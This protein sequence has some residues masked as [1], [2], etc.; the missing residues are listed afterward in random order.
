MTATGAGTTEETPEPGAEA[1]PAARQIITAGALLALILSSMDVSI[2]GT[3]LPR[4]AADLGALSLYSWVG[5]SYGMAAAVVIPIGGKLGDLFGR[6]PLLMAGL[7]GFVLASL[8]GALA[9]NMALLIVARTVQ[10]V[11][12]GLLTANIFTLIGEI[13]TAERRAQIQGVFFSVAGLGMVAGPPL[14]GVIT[15]NWGWRWVFWI[16]VPLGALALGAVTAV[17]FKQLG[18]RWQDIDFLGVLT[19]TAGLVPLLFGLSLTGDGHAWGSPEVLG[20]V[21]GGLLVLGLFCLVES[22]YARQPLVPFELFKVN[23][24]AVLVVVS[25]LSAVAMMGTTFYV[26]LL[27]QGVLGVSAT[28]SGSLLIP[29]AVAMMVVPP[30]T[31]K[32]LPSVPH[33]RYLG[34][35]AF[36]LL[37]VGLV[38]LSRVRPDS[39]DWMPL[40]AMVIIGIGVGIIFPLTTTVVQSAVPLQL[41]GVG[42]SQIQFWRTFASPVSI[43][44]LGTLLSTRAGGLGSGGGSGPSAERLADGLSDVFMVGAVLATIGLVIT[45]FLK[46]IPLRGSP[47]KPRPAVESEDA[48]SKDAT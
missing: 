48:A 40:L 37:A 12:A 45:L 33:Y 36:A 23:Q 28:Y 25:F 22:R 34:A 38:M 8:L 2:V 11:C 35:A 44:V 27:Y 39:G 32:Y 18:G 47:A 14:G 21:L 26:P 15:D 24:V 41:L 7:G 31:G 6:K 1:P 10:G 46:E 3:A 30:L 9:Q 17:P 43:A 13:Y 16:N 4:M 5:V 20:P 42:T 29:L 19:L